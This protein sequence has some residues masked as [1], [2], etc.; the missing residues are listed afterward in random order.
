MRSKFE[1]KK[2][3]LQRAGCVLIIIG[4]AKSVFVFFDSR[5]MIS[6]RQ[7]EASNQNVAQLLIAKSFEFFNFYEVQVYNISRC[8]LQI[9]GKLG[10]CRSSIV[11]LLREQTLK[12][13]RTVRFDRL[14]AKEHPVMK[15]ARID[16]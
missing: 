2:A 14:S 12:Q 16:H 1:L 9:E 13:S 10:F 5:L 6:R 8:L 7:V 3:K 4:A 15:E 11:V